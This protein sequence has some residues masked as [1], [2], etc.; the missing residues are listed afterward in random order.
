[1]QRLKCPPPLAAILFCFLPLMGCGD[2]KEVSYETEPVEGILT[3]DDKPIAGATVTF[4]PVTE[5]QGVSATGTTDESGKYTLT[6]VGKG[7][8]E[9]GA[10]TL[11]G[12]YFVG[13]VKSE[14]P[15]AG[16]HTEGQ[17][18]S[19]DTAGKTTK[20]THIIPEKYNDPKTSGLKVTVKEGDNVIPL[21]LTSK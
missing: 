9:P 5:G 2:K 18:S 10:G 15:S 1:M 20:M 4:I 16:D 11:P 14:F 7:A 3:L 19:A 6:A 8:G 13:V 21:T 12:E 17:A